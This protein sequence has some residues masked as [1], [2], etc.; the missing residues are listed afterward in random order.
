[1]K[2]QKDGIGNSR[3]ASR[4]TLSHNPDEGP[5]LRKNNSFL[6]DKAD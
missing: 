6:H 1:M 5:K 3:S 2:I 4:Y